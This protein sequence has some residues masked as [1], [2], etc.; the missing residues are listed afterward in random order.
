MS[1]AT[2]KGAL[3][4]AEIFKAL[5]FAPMSAAELGEYVCITPKAAHCWLHELEA[6][7]ML[8]TEM[9]QRGMGRPTHVYRL[10]PE[11]GGRA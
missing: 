7:G 6:N 8:T 11:W 4:M 5:R 3:V 1:D 2:R 10:S 9:Q